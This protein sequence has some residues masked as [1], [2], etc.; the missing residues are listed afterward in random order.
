MP[1]TFPKFREL[2]AEL[3]PRI[4]NLS[5]IPRLIEF[6]LIRQNSMRTFGQGEHWPVPYILNISGAHPVSVASLGGR[7]EALKRYKDD[8]HANYHVIWL[9][10]WGNTACQYPVYTV[11]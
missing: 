2:P 5:L 8:F 6:S 3:Q 1:S 4:W 9:D 10:A 7:N 11:Q